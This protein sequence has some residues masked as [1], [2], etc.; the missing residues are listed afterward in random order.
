MSHFMKTLAA[1]AIAGVLTAGSVGV[2][3]LAFINIPLACL[4]AAA[5][6]SLAIGGIVLLVRDTLRNPLAGLP[7]PQESADRVPERR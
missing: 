3:I 1:L 5:V 2:L 4:A 7:T 6:A